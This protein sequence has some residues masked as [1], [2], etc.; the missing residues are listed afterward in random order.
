MREV[1]FSDF[2]KLMILA[3]LDT[4]ADNEF[5]AELQDVYAKLPFW[6]IAEKCNEL[7][8]EIMRRIF[9]REAYAMMQNAVLRILKEKVKE[10]EDKLENIEGGD[11]DGK[12]K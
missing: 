12:N 6:F 8:F 11:K 2:D 5:V 1:F 10:L 7:D 4:E 3:I 9:S